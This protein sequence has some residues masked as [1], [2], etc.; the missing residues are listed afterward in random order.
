MAVLPGGGFQGE[1]SE[2][3]QGIETEMTENIEFLAEQYELHGA[4]V[5][6]MTPTEEPIFLQHLERFRRPAG[7]QHQS[8]C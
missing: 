5:T 8:T 6:R 3:I 2:S 4:P 1:Q 7:L